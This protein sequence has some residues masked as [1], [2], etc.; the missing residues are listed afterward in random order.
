M[1]PVSNVAWKTRHDCSKT[2]SP[3]FF[4]FFRD[5]APHG[6]GERKIWRERDTRDRGAEQSP[7]TGQSLN[8]FAEPQRNVVMT[9]SISA[10]VS[11]RGGCGETFPP[12]SCRLVFAPRV[13]A[14]C[15]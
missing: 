6:E 10:G 3:C 2:P 14:A 5:L 12:V 1:L 11:S 13:H 9:V 8:N 4:P 7:F 15:P